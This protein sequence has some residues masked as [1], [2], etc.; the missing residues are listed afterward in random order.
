MDF[1]FLFTLIFGLGATLLGAALAWW[2]QR[3]KINE[4]NQAMEAHLQTHQALEQK[5]ERD[6]KEFTALQKSYQT[7]D[8]NF[9]QRTTDF[10]TLDRTHQEM[11]LAFDETKLNLENEKISTTVTIEKLQQAVGTHQTECVELKTKNEHLEQ[12][13]ETRQVELLALQQ[14]KVALET[15]LTNAKFQIKNSQEQQEIL[16]VNQSQFQQ[17][18]QNL[19]RKLNEQ[20]TELEKERLAVTKLTNESLQANK[21]KEQFRKKLVE[22]EKLLANN[23]TT[24]QKLE[25]ESKTKQE[26]LASKEVSLKSTQE[27]LERLEEKAS[28]WQDEIGRLTTLSESKELLWTE[29]KNKIKVQEKKVLAI[30]EKHEQALERVG[31]LEQEKGQFELSIV[32]LET[33]LEKAEAEQKKVLEQLTAKETA[34]AVIEKQ[35]AEQTEELSV[36]KLAID[37]WNKKYE[38]TR[39]DLESYSQELDQMTKANEAL[40]RQ[41]KTLEEYNTTLES[42]WGTK[43]EQLK[44]EL[45]LVNKQL[46]ETKLEKSGLDLRV[47]SLSLAQKESTADWE[48]KYKTIEALLEEKNQALL[49]VDGVKIELENRIKTLVE[50]QETLK[51]WEGKASAFEMELVAQKSQYAQLHQEKGTLEKQLQDLEQTQ[52]QQEQQWNLDVGKLMNDYQKVV[53]TME[54]VHREKAQLLQ[55]MESIDAQQKMAIAAWEK[56]SATFKQREAA[57]LILLKA[58]QEKNEA[59]EELVKTLEAKSIKTNQNW[60]SKWDQLQEAFSAIEVQLKNSEQAQSELL[61]K[62]EAQKALLRRGDEAERE[63]NLLKNSLA[64]WRRKYEEMSR[65]YRN[66]EK[67]DRGSNLKTTEELKGYEAALDQLKTANQVL[68]TALNEREAEK[69]SVEADREKLTT[70]YERMLFQQVENATLIQKLES[71]NQRFKSQFVKQKNETPKASKA[72]KAATPKNKNAASLIDKKTATL[73]RIESK[74]ERIDFKRI[75]K[76]TAKQK[77]DLK[78]IKGIGPYIEEKLNALGIFQFNQIAKFT[79]DDEAIVNEAIE[80]F[81]G[82]VK[83]DKWVKQA[84]GLVKKKQ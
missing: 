82:R 13:V 32:H 61:E 63:T 17:Q 46:E 42:T 58:E 70:R 74:S 10:E 60:Q 59:N 18:N 84:I 4:L 22:K 36:L 35:N 78:T 51:Q 1:C 45:E 66:M 30:G 21:Q 83:R 68:K 79:N 11:R 19:E 31:L 65:A 72:T 6:S 34:L 40:H 48:S 43:Y 7:L 26:Q 77:D 23:R 37:D 27:K 29:A 73:K 12:L 14:D 16:I 38:A 69:V 2:W 41:I 76:A 33:K 44:K 24:L 20:Q 5:Y 67:T 71:E 57:G 50:E 55:S 49:N 47:N 8:Q 28:G 54:T 25:A 80:F 81:A 52:K 56:E 62:M 75:G 39:G 53:T 3:R 15:S 9:V 64:N